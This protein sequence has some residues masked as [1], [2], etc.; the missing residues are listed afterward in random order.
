MNE[1]VLNAGGIILTVEMPSTRIKNQ[2]QYHRVHT[3]PA[4][5]T[6]GLNSASAVSGRQLAIRVTGWPGD[7]L[8]GGEDVRYV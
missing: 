3:S 2:S 4:T 8:R 6:P 7:Y 5:R 1:C